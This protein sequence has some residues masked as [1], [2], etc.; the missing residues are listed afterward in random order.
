MRRNKKPAIQFVEESLWNGNC[1]RMQ[2][3]VTH[4][5]GNEKCP[6]SHIHKH[7]ICIHR[8]TQR[9]V[10]H[11]HG[12]CSTQK[13]N[14]KQTSKIGFFAITSTYF[15]V[16]VGHLYRLLN[17][18]LFIFLL[19]LFIHSQTHLLMFS[20]KYKWNTRKTSNKIIYLIKLKRD[21]RKLMM[22]MKYRR[23][24]G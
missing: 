14:K 23:R 5:Y 17:F 24:K 11:L 10:H 6:F 21:V 16:D 20:C 12:W 3:S 2:N 18:V 22:M 7:Y 15:S 19:C 1:D 8:S 4:G 13:K 9:T